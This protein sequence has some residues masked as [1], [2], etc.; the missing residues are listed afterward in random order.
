MS[1]SEFSSFNPLSPER[2]VNKIKVTSYLTVK[3]F[4][5]SIP[6]AIYKHDEKDKMRTS[7]IIFLLFSFN[8]FASEPQT[9]PP[10]KH[11]HE[12]NSVEH[13]FH[14]G[15]DNKYISEGRDSL[16]GDGLLTSDLEFGWKHLSSRIWY[17]ESPQQSYNEL[18]FSVAV[19][20][21]IN[22]TEL[23]LEYTHLRFPSDNQYDNEVGFG[24]SWS[25][26]PLDLEFSID[27]YYSFDTKGTFWE[28]SLNREYSISDKLSLTGAT[29]LGIN[30]G[31]V[32][33]GH[34]G[35][36]NLDLLI[37]SEY[38]MT[39]SLSVITH[40]GYSWALNREYQLSGDENLIDIFRGGVNLQWS[41]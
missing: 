24:V 22:N 2:Y 40:A 13:H 28:L 4:A 9:K 38:S 19:K 18:Q 21:V 29:V 30:E 34:D 7:L 5:F 10:F 31:Y 32:S 12:R 33:D 36:N 11:S 23:Y 1:D 26:L 20:E 25:T 41:F 3:F 15:F 37:E 27:G 16:N 39:K 35:T 14:I 8:A 6:S 17:G